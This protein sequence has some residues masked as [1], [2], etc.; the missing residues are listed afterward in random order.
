MLLLTANS[1]VSQRVHGVKARELVEGA[2]TLSTRFSENQRE[3][4]LDRVA[5]GIM[6]GGV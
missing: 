6:E 4:Q 1:E 3:C 2:P 5:Q